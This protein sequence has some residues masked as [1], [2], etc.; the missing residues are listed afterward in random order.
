MAK[1]A[2]Q[3]SGSQGKLKILLIALVA[4]AIV[5]GGGWFLLRT[6]R[7]SG[8]VKDLD[9]ETAEVR[10]EAI[11]R[12]A[13]YG[14]SAVPSVRKALGQKQGT[15]LAMA[16]LLAGKLEDKESV[17]RLIELLSD[18][19]AKVRECA[20]TALGQL[21]AQEAADALTNCLSDSEADVRRDA[22]VALG[23]LGEAGRPG[24]P[25]MMKLLAAKKEP[26]KVRRACAW[27]LGEIGDE[28]ATDALVKVITPK[29]VDLVRAVAAALGKIGSK[30]AVG[31]LC[32]FLTRGVP[33]EETKKYDAEN[34]PPKIRVAIVEALAKI[35][36]R[37]A[38]R[39]L[40]MCAD[41]KRTMSL[42][43]RDAAKKAL[44]EL[45]E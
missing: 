36:D 10:I 35:G 9:S 34:T 20:A 8:Y 43:V 19:N 41:E 27:A 16:A 2:D 17:P 15:G 7:L 31:P 24:M 18:S 14:S 38:V 1:S 33:D 39:T 5:V 40:K 12:I 44:Q 3:E 37:K 11:D 30:K 6:I 28:A 25:Q 4:I 26:A 45:G 32:S 42:I 13:E 22:V 29:D 23:I 21:R